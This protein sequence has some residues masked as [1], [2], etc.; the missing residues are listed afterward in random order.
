MGGDRA[1]WLFGWRAA[2]NIGPAQRHLDS[3]RADIAVREGRAGSE[4]ARI[5]RLRIH[6]FPNERAMMVVVLGHKIEMVCKSDR[7]L[8]ARVGNGARPWQGVQFVLT[9]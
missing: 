7:L 1:S 8:Q 3:T 2:I 6:Q 5:K 9:L 4:S